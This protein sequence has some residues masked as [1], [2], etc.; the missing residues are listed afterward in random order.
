VQAVIARG[1][2]V[3]VLFVA[4]LLA[5]CGGGKSRPAIA[6][7]PTTVGTLS[8]Q[9]KAQPVVQDVR[10]VRRAMTSGQADNAFV[11]IYDLVNRAVADKNAHHGDRTIRRE[12]PG[13]VATLERSYPS[14]RARVSALKLKS[15]TGREFQR[16][17][18]G[19]LHDDLV[20]SRS[21][22]ADVA[23]SQNAFLAVERWG[24]KTNADLRK[25]NARLR[26]IVSGA[27]ADQRTALIRAVREVFGSQVG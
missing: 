4:G 3:V 20:L 1:S 17:A 12:L 2:L 27:P 16:F 26:Q 19:I 25:D 22:N 23:R 10:A 13:L 18:L 6:P 21:L 11:G 24:N 5:G 8:Q 7:P 9:S 14:T 15:S